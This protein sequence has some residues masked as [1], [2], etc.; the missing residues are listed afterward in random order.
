[1]IDVDRFSFR[2]G[3]L[4][5]VCRLGVAV[6]AGGTKNKRQRLHRAQSN[7]GKTNCV[8][9]VYSPTIGRLPWPC[10]TILWVPQVAVLRDPMSVLS[11]A[12]TGLRVRRP[13]PPD[14]GPPSV[15]FSKRNS[16]GAATLLCSPCQSY[17]ITPTA[18]GAQHA[19]TFSDRI[20]VYWHCRVD[21]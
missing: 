18:E 16:Q 12:R 21:R 11:Q 5:C 2:A 8:G 15:R 19:Q 4:E 20:L 14:P 3:Q 17:R 1:L 10:K 13:V 7:E 9:W 6:C